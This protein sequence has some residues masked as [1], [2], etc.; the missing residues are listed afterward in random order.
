MKEAGL[1]PITGPA[2]EE[3][4]PVAGFDH[5]CII[6]GLGCI[7]QPLCEFLRAAG[8]PDIGPERSGFGFNHPGVKP[9]RQIILNLEV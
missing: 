8:I 2:N 6:F 7:K 4:A 3:A 9:L 1:K 5:L